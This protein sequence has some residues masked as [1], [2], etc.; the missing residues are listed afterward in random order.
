MKII[1][2][3]VWSSKE[4]LDKNVLW[5]NNGIIKYYGVNGWESL[6]YYSKEDDSIVGYI[7]EETHKITLSGLLPEDT[8]YLRYEDDKGSKVRRKLT[9]KC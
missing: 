8:Y 2:D 4:P 7:T 9:R 6:H 3:I 1:R 5:L